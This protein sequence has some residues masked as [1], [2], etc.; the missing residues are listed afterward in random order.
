LDFGEKGVYASYTPF[1]LLIRNLELR[2]F[3]AEEDDRIPTI[4]ALHQAINDKFN[5]AGIVIAFPQRDLHLDTIQPL[6]LRIHR[7]KQDSV[8]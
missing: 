8:G 4:S 7:G 5:Q 1:M 3:V 6:D 2:Y